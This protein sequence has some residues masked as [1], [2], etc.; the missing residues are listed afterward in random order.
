MEDPSLFPPLIDWQRW[1]TV[2]P[3]SINASWTFASGNFA[4]DEGPSDIA[5][6]NPNDG[7]ICIGTN[8]IQVSGTRYFKLGLPWFVLSPPEGWTVLAGKIVGNSR[9]D[10]FAYHPRDGSILVLRNTG[11]S[12]SSEKWATMEPVSGWKFAIGDFTGDG[13][14][15]IAAYYTQD[16]SIW[17]GSQKIKSNGQRYFD[18]T[19]EWGKRLNPPDGWVFEAGNFAGDGRADLIGYHPSDGSIYVGRNTGTNSFSWS[20]WATIDKHIPFNMALIPGDFSGDG[21]VG[22][23]IYHPGDGS[24]RVASKLASE[25]RFIVRKWSSVEPKVN[26]R[27]LSGHFTEINRLDL[28]AYYPSEDASA[29]VGSLWIGVNL[30]PPMGY[31]WPISAAPGEKIQFMASGYLDSVVRFYRYGT[32]EKS[33]DGILMESIA[34]I[35]SPRPQ[36]FQFELPYRNGCGWAPSFSLVIPDWISGLY[37]ARLISAVN[38]QKF[39]ITFIIK[40][41]SS[42]HS[43][44]AVIVNVNT[45]NAYNDWGGRSKYDGAARTSFLRPNFYA[46]PVNWG[47]QESHSAG[48]ERW[49]FGWL[50]DNGYKPDLFTDIDFHNGAVTFEEGY[51]KIVV[52]THPEYWTIEMRQ[53]LKDFL[54][55][56]GSFVY[57]GGNGMFETVSYGPDQTNAIYLLGVEDGDR[58]PATFRARG[59]HERELLGVAS[60]RAVGTGDWDAAWV[61]DSLGDGYKVLVTTQTPGTDIY[62]IF[63]MTGLQLHSIFG[64]SGFNKVDKICNGAASGHEIDTSYD[65]DASH[66]P[67]MVEPEIT[68]IKSRVPSNLILLAEGQNE[69]GGAHMTFYR[70]PSGGFVFSAGS[71]TFGGSLAESDTSP[72]HHLIKNVMDLQSYPFSL[73][74]ILRA[75]SIIFPASLR[76][77][78]YNY[79]FVPP[80]SVRKLIQKLLKQ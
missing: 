32:R 42:Q 61:W 9:T 62:E 11:S 1:G 79:G 76:S 20:Q 6:Y 22:L 5:A 21:N 53:R 47:F 12:F 73:I 66:M 3:S 17:V 38:G 63:K 15:D 41:P 60:A 33:G 49:I 34:T 31:A 74:K 44:V 24:I 78:A 13:Q 35:A 72:V 54:D 68:G 16:G 80:I 64:T 71:I 36:S 46:S 58:S 4:S 48:A 10:L 8:T 67:F 75:R 69:N 18:F 25:D 59:L 55:A 57:L 19:G 30:Y 27:L 50:E 43:R 77:V 52:G 70:H 40:P 7:T 29:D 56:G 26:W 23:A 2:S 37:S 28:F 45:W 51:R 14:L 39:D 65:V